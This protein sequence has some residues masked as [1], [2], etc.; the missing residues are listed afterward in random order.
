[1][2]VG[3]TRPAGGTGTAP[4]AGRACHAAAC[5]FAPAIEVI[6]RRE[7]VVHQRVGETTRRRPAGRR[8]FGHG[9]HG[10]T[11]RGNWNLP[12]PP[13]RQAARGTAVLLRSFGCSPDYTPDSNVLCKSLAMLCQVARQRIANCSEPDP[14]SNRNRRLLDDPADDLL[15][16]L[17]VIL[18]E[19]RATNEREIGSVIRPFRA[20]GKPAGKENPC[21][22]LAGPPIAGAGLLPP[23]WP[24]P[25]TPALAVG[26]AFQNAPTCVKPSRNGHSC[27]QLP[28]RR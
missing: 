11:R 15:R 25:A 28:A 22:S 14:Q 10:R 3:P 4:G 26:Y 13:P 17:G 5:V 12:M 6:D 18:A 24:N 7:P 9:G 21:P 20:A 16:V 1:V 8:R 19:I 2:P 27:H 23:V